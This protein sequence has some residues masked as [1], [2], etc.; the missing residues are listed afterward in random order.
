VAQALLPAASAL[1]P[2]LAFDTV[3]RPRTTAFADLAACHR[4]ALGD[5]EEPLPRSSRCSDPVLIELLSLGERKLW[6]K[7]QL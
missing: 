7:H 2:T 1:L 4:F 3:S 5:L 6:I